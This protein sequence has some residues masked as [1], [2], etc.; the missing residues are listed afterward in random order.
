MSEELTNY[1]MK[2]KDDEDWSNAKSEVAEAYSLIVDAMADNSKTFEQMQKYTS[3]LIILNS[4]Q[5][6]LDIFHKEANKE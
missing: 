2:M 5:E 4:Y 6:H 1:I 3:I